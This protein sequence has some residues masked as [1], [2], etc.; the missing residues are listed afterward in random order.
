M[1]TRGL[2]G[3]GSRCENSTGRGQILPILLGNSCSIDQ[4]SGGIWTGQVDLQQ[5]SPKSDR[6]IVLE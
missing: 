2:S 4:K 1:V 5:I 6:L 3:L